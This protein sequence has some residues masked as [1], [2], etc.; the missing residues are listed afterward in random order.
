[1]KR[2]VYTVLLSL[3]EQVESLKH[4]NHTVCDTQLSAIWVLII[5]YVLVVFEYI[6]CDL[7]C[8]FNPT[9]PHLFLCSFSS[10]PSRHH[11]FLISPPPPRSYGPGIDGQLAASETAIEQ[12][13]GSVTSGGGHHQVCC[14]AR[15][16]RG[17]GE[18]ETTGEKQQREGGMTASEGGGKSLQVSVCLCLYIG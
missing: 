16:H 1:M 18:D 3:H 4:S 14:E 5:G 17:A 11:F 8:F 7:C 13:I 2:T 15:G 12:R 6:G 10:F 9:R